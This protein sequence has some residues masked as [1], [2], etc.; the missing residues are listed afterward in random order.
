MHHTGIP[1]SRRRA[2]LTSTWLVSLALFGAGGAMAQEQ[3]DPTL[4]EIV[5]TARKVEENLQSVP[6][7]VTAISGEGLERQNAVRLS[8]MAQVAPGLTIR[9]A[10]NNAS[11]VALQIRGQYQNDNLATLDPS[12][13]TYVDGLYWAR[14]Y[15]LNADFLDVQSAQVLRGPQGTL[16]GRNTTGGAMLVQTND[17][18]AGAFSAMASASYGRFDERS[19]MAVVNIPLAQDRVALRLAG[20]F[21]KRDGYIEDA[22]FTFGAASTPTAIAAAFPL[23]D[24]RSVRGATGRQ[25]G[26]RDTWT[27][28]GK[29]LLQPT[30]DLRIVLSAKRR[31]TRSCAS[32]MFTTAMADRSSNRP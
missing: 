27:L 4:E 2:L 3:A 14:A 30:D 23:S 22:P 15:G 1:A 8:D 28:R 13:G 10:S 25:L 9:P 11:A 26:D 31:A 7:A 12:V 29:L 20:S 16:F 18:D 21:M 19:A 32:G 5:V 24:P 17:P 6:V